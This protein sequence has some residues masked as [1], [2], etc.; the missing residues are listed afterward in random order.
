MTSGIDV[1]ISDTKIWNDAVVLA[2][3]CEDS[4]CE[5]WSLTKNSAS[6]MVVGEEED[7]IAAIRAV[8]F[9]DLDAGDAPILSY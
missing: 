2:W 4:L 3:I 8:P 7:M 1:L 9:T 6:F 5:A